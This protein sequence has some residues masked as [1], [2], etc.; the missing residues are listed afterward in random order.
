MGALYE[1]CGHGCDK[2]LLL[3]LC[4]CVCCR[5]GFGPIRKDAKAKFS[6]TLRRFKDSNGYCNMFGRLWG[7]FDPLDEAWCDYYLELLTELIEARAAK[8]EAV[9]TVKQGMAFMVRSGVAVA[10][11]AR[12]RC[13][14]RGCCACVCVRYC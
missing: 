14:T 8:D 3:L 7:V 12:V 10:C 1:L 11:G 13:E 9:I 4:V 5:Y 2:L 6:A